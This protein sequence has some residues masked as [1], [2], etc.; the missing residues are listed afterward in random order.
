[1]DSLRLC[2]RHA[3]R[4]LLRAPLTTATMISCI[5]LGIGPGLAMFGVLD[6]S[7]FKPLPLGQPHEI[8][9]LQ[10][11]GSSEI[12]HDFPHPFAE[13]AGTAKTVQ[14]SAWYPTTAVARIG[15]RSEKLAVEVVSENYFTTLGVPM[16]RGTAWWG[17]GADARGAILSHRYWTSTLAGD[18]SVIGRTVFILGRT[19]TVIGVAAP[20]F[21]GLRVGTLV[22]L[23]LPMAVA[24]AILDREDALVSHNLWWT[25]VVGRLRPGATMAASHAELD[26]LLKGYRHAVAGAHLTPERNAEIDREGLLVVDGSRG[27][28]QVRADR[29]QLP[30]WLVLIG[31]C[32]LLLVC[33][34]VASLTLSGLSQRAQEFGIKLSMGAPRRTLFGQV[35]VEHVLIVLCGTLAGLLLWSWMRSFL[36]QL[37]FGPATKLDLSLDW[38]LSVVA[39]TMM[40]LATAILSLVGIVW[41]GRMDPLT[42]LR[43]TVNASHTATAGRSSQRWQRWVLLVQ[44]GLSVLLVLQAAAFARSF[45]NLSQRELGFD[46]DHVVVVRLDAENA[47]LSPAAFLH[48]Q[49][50]LLDE[51]RGA[52]W[53]QTAA[54]A[55]AAP[56]DSGQ[57]VFDNIRVPGDQ[58]ACDVRRVEL[59]L[60]DREYFATLGIRFLAGRP[61]SSGR[62]PATAGGDPTSI[63]V[64]INETFARRCFE[65][66]QA[67]GR[68]F[69][70]Y[71]STSLQIA[72]VAGDARYHSLKA[73]VGAVLYAPY[74]LWP[75]GGAPSA[76]LLIRSARPPSQLVS[77]MRQAV[78]RLNRGVEVR[79]VTTVAA[80]VDELLRPERTLA[81]GTGFVMLLG[82][83]LVG[84]G[85]YGAIAQRINSRMHE[86]AV[87]L[88]LGARLTHITMTAAGSLALPLAIGAALGYAANTPVRAVTKSLLFG[89]VEQSPATLVAAGLVVLM[90]ATAA[91]TIP[92]MRLRRIDVNTVLRGE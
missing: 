27:M 62:G 71:Q 39:A 16:F 28:S 12:E 46:R 44:V 32:T 91:A 77:E 56:L 59:Q 70:V 74:D 31:A 2:S 34:N 54:V 50:T 51:V 8:V 45:T 4:A 63:P 9:L 88:A 64:V 37:L 80:Q 89:T 86:Y 78:G 40:L 10:R 47:A 48:F 49:Q 5:A 68:S 22:D 33:S 57:E 7:V 15:E 53:V 85:V 3:V 65:P 1:M 24:P 25:F 73:N 17:G 21:F 36:P 52:G 43:L 18:P 13:L 83:L 87:R 67:I 75:G 35:A 42:L 92:L 60:V 81:Q 41:I 69:T 30:V 58:Q 79:E 82:L 20:G 26:A 66:S 90:V 19:Y 72:G 61:P 55:H 11:Q 84:I 6:A 38:R 23:W 14:T 29:G 76:T